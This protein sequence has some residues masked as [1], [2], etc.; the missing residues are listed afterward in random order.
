MGQI[1]L[2]R[3]RRSSAGAYSPPFAY[4]RRRA[5]AVEVRV[6]APKV[7]VAL[8][9]NRVLGRALAVLPVQA[10]HDPQPLRHLSNG[11]EAERIQAPVVGQIDEELRRAGVRSRAREEIGRAHV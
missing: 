8:Q 11:T 9:A 7:W 6:R 1:A 2:A 10:V 5:D 3:R 4:D